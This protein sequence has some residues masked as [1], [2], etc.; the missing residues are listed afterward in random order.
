MPTQDERLTAL[1]QAV[2]SQGQDMR[3]LFDQLSEIRAEIALGLQRMDAHFDRITE[4]LAH[5]LQK[6]DQ[7]T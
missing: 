4:Q 3:L 1:E 6:L 7:R 2:K 5:I